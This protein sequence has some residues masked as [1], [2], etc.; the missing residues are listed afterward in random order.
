MARSETEACTYGSICRRRPPLT[1]ARAHFHH[2]MTS[3]GRKVLSTQIR[4]LKYRAASISRSTKHISPRGREH[5][6]SRRE[7]KGSAV[8]LGD[9]THCAGT[10]IARGGNRVYTRQYRYLS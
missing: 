8:E 6:C 3:D 4:N 9:T 7:G 5:L 1:R 10:S 2:S